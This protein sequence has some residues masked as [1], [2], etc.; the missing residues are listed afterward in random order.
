MRLSARTQPRPAG[1]WESRHGLVLPF[2][3]AAGL[4]L[5]E[6]GAFWL[7]LRRTTLR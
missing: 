1:G 2:A 7:H 5:T 4:E 6:A 3:M